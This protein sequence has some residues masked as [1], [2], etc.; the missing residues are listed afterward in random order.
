[1]EFNGEALC[2]EGVIL[3]T[4]N[5]RVNYFGFF[6]HPDLAAENENKV[7]GNYGM[8]DQIAALKW[9]QENIA[10]FGGNPDN[11]T[12]FGQ[13][14]GGSSVA[15]HLCSDA[16]DG[17]F[18]KAIIQ[19]GS[20]GMVS[21]ALGTTL[22]E[23]EAWGVKACQEVGKTVEELRALSPGELYDA[24]DE[25][26]EKTGPYPRR[27]V[28]GVLYKETSAQALAN[29]HMKNI[30]I[31]TGAVT[32]DNKLG[33]ADP[34]GKLA[35][36]PGEDIVA[37][38]DS[39]IAAKQAEEG[40]IPAYV[41]C[42]DAYIPDGDEYHFIED[43]ETY[44]SAE[45]WYVFGTLDRCWRHFDGRHHDLS[46]KIIKYWTNFAKTGDPNGEGLPRWDA[47]TKDSATKLYLSEEKIEQQEIRH[48]DVVR[49][50]LLE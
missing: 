6:A 48:M 46:H 9:V 13:S 29:G 50:A 19:S 4:I 38:G 2:K 8:L 15:S 24:L 21:N 14:A 3:V 28:D 10:A 35:N 25:V 26:S 11:V 27:A 45:L 44:H 20:F 40:R 22:E 5:Y 47:V 31:M 37:L 41:F 18:H 16:T 30:P 7:S 36:L 1:M 23:A 12:I 17:L 34:D 42:M 33:I 49:E 39:A 43:G 32:G